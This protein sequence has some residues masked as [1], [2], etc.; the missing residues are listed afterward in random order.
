M[1]AELPITLHF[2]RIGLYS[3]ALFIVYLAGSY[4]A[5][6]F[7]YLFI[8]LL[9]LPILSLSYLLLTFFRLKYYQDFSTEHPMK[10]ES[11]VY[12]LILAN[13]TLL[14]L[15][16]LNVEFKTIHPYMEEVLP[17]F[18]TYIRARQRLESV[19]EI[20]CPFRGIYTVGLESLAAEDPLHFFVF[21]RRV[22]YR[23]FYVY[24]RVLPLRSFSTG[25]ERSERLAQGSSTGSVPDYALFSQ[26]RSYRHGESLRHAAWKKF[27]STGTPFLKVYDTSAEPGVTI[28]F[29]LRQTK[30]AGLKALETEDI[31]IDILVALV[32]YYLD[33]DVPVTVRAPG[34]TVYTFQGFGQSSFQRFYL[35]TM[36]L[37]FQPT[38]SPGAMYH[39]DKQTGGYES[40]SAIIISH[41]FDPEVF[42]TVDESLSGDSPVSLILNRSGYPRAE[43]KV[44]L[45]YLYSLSERGA[46]VRFVDG[47]EDIVESLEQGVLRYER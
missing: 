22:W 7:L 41:L 1:N 32:K 38:I 36:E 30:A 34:R 18:T 8:I 14:P 23:T 37:L 3:L 25:M 35:S 20:H 10:G 27:A 5:P 4:V 19:Y 33:H 13:E 45:P 9:I 43:R 31:S 47:P 15:H 44:I 12:R 24:P 16:Y 26:L 17:R 46:N 42:S 21:R 6:F 2:D 29:D 39:L 40:T 28:Y 11:V